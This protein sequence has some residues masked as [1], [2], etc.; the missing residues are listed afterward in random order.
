MIKEVYVKCAKRG[1]N[2]TWVRL[3]GIKRKLCL[4]IVLLNDL[5]GKKGFLKKPKKSF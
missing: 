5:L 4:C 1:E 3:K 2:P